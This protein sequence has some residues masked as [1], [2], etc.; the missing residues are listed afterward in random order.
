MKGEKRMN[1]SSMVKQL[2]EQLIG[3]HIYRSLPHGIDPIQDIVNSLPRYRAD[4]VFDIGANVGQSSKFYLTKFPNSHIYCFEPVSDTFRQ[5]QN[6]LEGN[7]RVDCYQLAFGS[8]KGRGKMVLQGEFDTFFLLNQSKESSINSNVL[9]E[10][11]DV[12]T[13]DEFC[14]M[15]GID[16]I[17][18]LKI[19]TEGGDLEVLKG[20]V[21]MLTEQRI[22]C[23]QVEAGMNSSNNRHVPLELLKE[24]LES[25]RYFL[26]GIYEQMSE[27]YMNGKPHLR[28]TNLLFISYN[29]IEINRNRS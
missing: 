18:Y 1:L 10:S 14:H 2:I 15:K 11:V 9:T 24:F 26:F 27:W 21:N 3:I 12:V 19:D 28:W 22:D 8:A 4:I 23:V 6:N 20:A 17:S 13:L 16:R 29:M 5:L 7:K 25:H